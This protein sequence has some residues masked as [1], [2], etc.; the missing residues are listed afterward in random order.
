MRR[1][2]SRQCIRNLPC[3]LLRHPLPCLLRVR[4]DVRGQHNLRQ[5][6]QPRRN[7]RFIRV[8]VQPCVSGQCRD[9]TSDCASSSGRV[10]L[11]TCG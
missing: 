10:T 4:A 11:S 8:H 9:S 6:D 3:A 7:V 2:F 1:P 5:R